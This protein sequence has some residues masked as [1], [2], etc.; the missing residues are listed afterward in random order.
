MTDK[1]QF[2]ADEW[3]HVSRAPA[4]AAMYLI[5][6]EKGGTLRESMAVGKVYAEVRKDSTGS[7][8]VDEIVASLSSISPKEFA[9]KEQFQ[10][11]AVGQVRAAKETLAAKADPEE[12]STYGDFIVTVVKR[13]AEADKSGGFMGIGGERVTAQETAAIEEIRAAVS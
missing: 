1:A 11:E 10:A 8:L 9:D 7:P 12:V 13:V 4:I 2:D 6:A 3:E 5:S